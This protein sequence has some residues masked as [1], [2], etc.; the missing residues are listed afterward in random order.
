MAGEVGNMSS[1]YSIGVE[2]EYMLCDNTGDLSNK[3]N[4]LMD[5]LPKKMLD[6]YSYELI[7]SEFESNT[8]VHTDVNECMSEVSLLRNTI[9]DI[10]LKNNF[11]I[12]ISGTHPTAKTNNQEFVVN[13]SYNWVS[14]QLKY[15]ATKN[16]TFSIHVHIGLDDKDKL[17]KVTNT[18]RRWIAPML[19]LS[20]NSPFFEGENTGM[21][22]SRTF[23]FG[24]FPRTEIP[25][26]IKSF[27]D[28]EDLI[29]KYIETKTISK[30]RQIWWKI[31]PHYDYNTIEF[32]VCDVQRSFEKTEMIIALVQAL[33]RTIVVNRD[34]DHDYCYEYLTDALWKAS[35]KNFSCTIIDPYDNKL[36][37]MNSMI[38]KMIAYCKDSLNYFGNTHVLKSVEDILD[39]GTEAN[40]QI[41]LYNESGFKKLKKYLMNSVDYQYKRRNNV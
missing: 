3:A 27:N 12:G 41:A 20:T 34:Y 26:F 21:L 24:L 35:S 5:V 15:Y 38:N 18:L 28:Y 33:V 7:L 14:D 16:I 23:Q 32:R 30:P 40:N 8:S 19:A 2:E 29:N 25:T 10:A 4:L 22:S 39:N 17:V 9:N 13:N 6:R 36:I 37:S 1:N 31:R 11:R